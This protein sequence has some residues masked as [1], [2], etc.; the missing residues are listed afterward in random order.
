MMTMTQYERDVESANLRAQIKMAREHAGRTTGEIREANLAHMNA[1]IEAL[2]ELNQW[3]Y[4]A[5]H[6]NEE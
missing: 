5:A 4:T 2:R 1:A 6:P 3:R